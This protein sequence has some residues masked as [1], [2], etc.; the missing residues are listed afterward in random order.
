MDED[1][2]IEQSPTDVDE[3]PESESLEERIQRL[4][5]AFKM[6]NGEDSLGLA[7]TMVGTRRRIELI[8]HISELLDLMKDYIS[9]ELEELNELYK[10]ID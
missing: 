4:G 1:D 8:N 7:F 5:Y 6:I 9:V 3:E 2:I 10:I